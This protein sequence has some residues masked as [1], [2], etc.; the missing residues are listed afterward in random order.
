MQLA[1]SELAAQEAGVK[2]HARA[3]VPAAVKL[4]NPAVHV[5]ARPGGSG[6]GC[7]VQPAEEYDC[8]TVFQKLQR[9]CRPVLLPLTLAAGMVVGLCIVKVIRVGRL[10]TGSG[11]NGPPLMLCSICRRAMLLRPAAAAET[12]AE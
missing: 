5:V 8:V 2:V 7:T 11:T 6:D 4:P 1:S 3:S 9:D 12:G 10:A